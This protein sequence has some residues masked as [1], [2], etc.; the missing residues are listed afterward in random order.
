MGFGAI[1]KVQL[2]AWSSG[3]APNLVES[4]AAARP[5]VIAVL[6]LEHD[7]QFAFILCAFM[8]TILCRS[9]LYQHPLPSPPPLQSYRWVQLPA[10]RNFHSGLAGQY[11]GTPITAAASLFSN[12]GLILT[13]GVAFVSF[14]I[15]PATGWVS[16]RCTD[17]PPHPKDVRISGSNWPL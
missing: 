11:S 2:S 4:Q 14:L 9:S 16:S 5:S 6:L 3:A 12:P 1:S 13:S 10:S 7:S 8:L 17:F 15:L